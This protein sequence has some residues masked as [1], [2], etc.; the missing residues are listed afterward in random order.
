MAEVADRSASAGEHIFLG[1]GSLS[2]TGCEPER[3][4]Q[5]AEAADQGDAGDG[6][7]LTHLWPSDCLEFAY[8]TSTGGSGQPDRAAIV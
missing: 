5:G 1:N 8:S 3:A 4:V 2:S 6:D 7:R